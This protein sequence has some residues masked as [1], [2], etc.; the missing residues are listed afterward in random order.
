[1]K[2]YILLVVLLVIVTSCSQK[3]EILDN[4]NP[5]QI[6]VITYLDENNNRVMDKGEPVVSDSVG[7][8]QDVSCPA[9]NLDAVTKAETDSAGEVL[10][11]ELKPGMYCVMYMGSRPSTTKLTIEVPLNSDQEILVGFGLTE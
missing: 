7:I 3:P 1:M 11:D 2:K 10:F 8:S 9:G 5:G 6:K 4:G